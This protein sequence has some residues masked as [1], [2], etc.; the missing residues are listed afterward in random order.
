M[1]PE[2]TNRPKD[3]CQQEM[4][5]SLLEQ[6]AKEQT[7]RHKPIKKLCERC[8]KEFYAHHCNLKLGK[9]KFCSA[10]CMKL[11]K[12]KTCIVCGK[13]YYAKKCHT[14]KGWGN[15]CSHKCVCKKTKQHKGKKHTD[16]TK[17]RLSDINKGKTSPNKGKHMTEETKMKLSEINK[18]KRCGELSPV[19]KGGISFEPY[20]PKWT[21]ELR[22]RVRAFFEYRCVTCGKHVNECK[23]NLQVHH[24]EYNKQACCDGKPVHFAALCNSC[25]MKTNFNRE[26]WETMLH[27]IIDEIY[28]GRSYYTKEEYQRIN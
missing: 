17:Q 9:D 18:G 4:Q 25:H 3:L 20:C 12:I 14:D 24:V 5:E 7:K 16:E 15:F 23:R 11:G 13:Q 27:R 8:G 10:E 6:G 1:V 19:W 28:N 22:E 26:R 2:I 21:K